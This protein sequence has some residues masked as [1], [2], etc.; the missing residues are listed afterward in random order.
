[1]SDPIPDTAPERQFVRPFPGLRRFHDE[2]DIPAAEEVTDVS[3]QVDAEPPSDDLEAESPVAELEPEPDA[4]AAIEEAVNSANATTV[5]G[6][7]TQNTTTNHNTNI[8]NGQQPERRRWKADWRNRDSLATEAE[9]TVPPTDADNLVSV[10]A[11]NRFVLLS[12]PVKSGQRTS[13][14]YLVHRM[15]ESGQAGDALRAV[16]VLLESEDL[17]LADAVD[18]HADSAL[19]VDLTEDDEMAVKVQRELDVISENLAKADSYL[20]LILPDGP[21]SRSLAGRLLVHPLPTPGGHEVFRVKA[22]TAILP[23]VIDELLE[24]P[25]LDTELAKARPPTAAWLAS[26]ARDLYETDAA[27][28]TIV[29]ELKDVGNDWRDRLEKEIGEEADP[30]LRSLIM[31]AALFPKTPAGVITAAADELQRITKT[32]DVTPPLCQK[33]PNRRL[34]VLTNLGFDVAIRDFRRPGYG[35]AIMPYFWSTFISL[36]PDLRHWWVRLMTHPD[37]RVFDLDTTVQAVVDV[38]SKVDTSIGEVAAR[39]VS[40]P[41]KAP[42]AQKARWRNAAVALLG[43]AAVDNTQG[44][45]VRRT[46]WSWARSNSRLRRLVVAEVC[47]LEFGQRFPHNALTRLKHLM[48]ADDKVVR[49]AAS[50]SLRQMAVHVGFVEIANVVTKWRPDT[51]RS[52]EVQRVLTELV[53][54]PDA[55][56][57]LAE[58]ASGTRLWGQLLDLLDYGMK[59]LIA[60]LLAKVVDL[61]QDRQDALVT[62]LVGAVDGRQRRYDVLLFAANRSWTSPGSDVECLHG[63]VMSA[64]DRMGPPVLAQAQH[65]VPS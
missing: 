27:V 18:A 39:L 20:V 5:A 19:I 24:D 57:H 2:T 23:R 40:P 12:S 53:M 63:R 10:L 42:D 6:D 45:R 62:D 25:W 54:E 49:D 16:T 38:A 41:D 17:S 51:V 31:A 58:T 14:R 9:T 22:G 11:E 35:A 56:A 64:L 32:N 52:A 47:A 61:P 15:I 33:S 26:A 34:E 7:F 65:E 21:I 59:P 30:E 8:F 48:D 3:R 36:Q 1:M 29:A 37:S 28:S 55:I 50:R 4:V 13:A 44:R 60:E 43:A 46:L